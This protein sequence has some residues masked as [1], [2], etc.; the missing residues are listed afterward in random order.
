MTNPRRYP[1]VM[2]SAESGR[3]MRRGVKQVT[4]TVDGYDFVYGQPGW[5]CS[6]DDPKDDEGQLVDDDNVIRAAALREARAKAKHSPLTPLAIKAIR[7]ACDLS[8][9]EASRVFGGGPK[10]FEKYEAGEIAPSAAMVRLLLLAAQHPALFRKS[11]GF[12]KTREAD[13]RLIR[14][15]VRKSSVNKIWQK[16]YAEQAADRRRRA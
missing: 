6:L 5:W 13:A 3:P 12:A 2:I 9:R 14:D 10:A 4:I 1:N 15:T 16:V 8:Q 11:R 7:E